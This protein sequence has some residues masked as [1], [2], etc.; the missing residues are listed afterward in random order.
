MQHSLKLLHKKNTQGFCNAALY[1]KL[2][3][4]PTPG[5]QVPR[6]VH[7]YNIYSS[8]HKSQPRVQIHLAHKNICIVYG[9][10]KF[11]RLFSNTK[12]LA[13]VCSWPWVRIT[14]WVLGL[15][16]MESGYENNR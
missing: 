16:V 6:T 14:K 13:I 10:T 4:F 11:P 1:N 9:H 12:Y 8:E 7:N 3:K 5:A 15:T 2:L